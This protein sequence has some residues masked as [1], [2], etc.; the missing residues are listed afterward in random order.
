MNNVAVGGVRSNGKTWA[1]YE[2]I[3][4]GSGGR[5]CCDGVD[6]VHTNMT[7]TLNTP[8]EILE[9]EYP[10]FF[11]EYSIRPD[12]GGPGKY[13]GGNGII[14]AFMVLENGVRV[15]VTGERVKTRPWG[16]EGGKNG[17]PAEYLVVRSNGR[18]ERLRSKDE[19]V[20]NKGDILY[21]K[22]AGGGG[23]GD[24]CSR[25]RKMIEEDLSDSKISIDVAVK[26]YCYS[27]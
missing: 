12:S 16:L 21:I 15:V 24:P 8:I 4:C 5:P 13:R 19:T 18:V 1:F 2:T 25:D 7:N 17:A 23:Y 22:T 26:D 11:I 10:V 27:P 20:L 6:A 14:R 9:R 3:G